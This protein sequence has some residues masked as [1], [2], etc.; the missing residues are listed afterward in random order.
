MSTVAEQLRQAREAHRLT[1]RQVADETKIRSDHIEALEEGNYD[2]FSAQIYVRGFVRTY[3]RLLKLNELSVLATLDEEL[4]QSKKFRALPPLTDRK[5]TIV[6]T[7]T[8]LLSKI[9]WKVGLVIGGAIVVLGI[10]A[11]VY[12]TWHHYKTADPL[13]GLAPGIYSAQNSGGETIPLPA[14]SPRH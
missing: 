3:A 1:T 5:H 2:V 10:C 7:L 13:A 6:D 9:N 4:A 11:S 14:S 8:L 12:A